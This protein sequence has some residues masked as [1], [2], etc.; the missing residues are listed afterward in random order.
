MRVHGC[1]E[2]ASMHVPVTTCELCLR[3]L[4]CAGASNW[5]ARQH[6]AWARETFLVGH[7]VGRAARTS[8]R[9]AISGAAFEESSI[10][11]NNTLRNAIEVNVYRDHDCALMSTAVLFLNT[12]DAIQWQW[13][14]TKFYQSD[15]DACA[16]TPQLQENTSLIIHSTACIRTL[17]S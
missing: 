10:V 8:L 17:T 4:V 7:G 5:Q 6:K 12:L 1:D 14:R 13:S 11:C 9:S 2:S 3:G 16:T 15:S